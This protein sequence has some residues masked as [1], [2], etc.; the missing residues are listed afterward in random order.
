MDFET[1]SKPYGYNQTFDV[2]PP[3]VR[4]AKDMINLPEGH[5]GT[6]HKLRI[7]IQKLLT[8]AKERVIREV[9][10]KSG[11]GIFLKCHYYVFLEWALYL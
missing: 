6:I 9:N 8:M 3:R 7:T 2:S 11:V 5:L 4:R 1:T 10:L